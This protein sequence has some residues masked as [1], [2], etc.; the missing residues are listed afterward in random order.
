MQE[1]NSQPKIARSARKSNSAGATRGRK[2]KSLAD[3]AVRGDVRTLQSGQTR[4][5]TMSGGRVVP[6]GGTSSSGSVH[7]GEQNFEA[8]QCLGS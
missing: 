1:D 6:Q 4:V 3:I 2:P 8:E 5:L 7:T